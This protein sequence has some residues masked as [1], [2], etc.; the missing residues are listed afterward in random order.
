MRIEEN[1]DLK[2]F[3]SYRLEARC[4]RAFFPETVEE[5]REAFSSGSVGKVLLGSGH[6]IILSKEWYEE[7]FIIFNGNFSNV[8]V[9]A[10]E[11]F[12]EAGSLS[13]VLSEVAL[14]HSLTGLE[15]LYDIPSSL[16]GALVMNAGASGFDIG[17]I[18]KCIKILDLA[19]LQVYDIDPTEAKFG[20]RESIF[21]EDRRMVVLSA[22]LQLEPGD[23]ATILRQMRLFKTQRWAKQPRDLPNAGSVFK[24]PPGG[25]VG[26]MIE[27]VG[28]KGYRL[29]GASISHKHAGIIVNEGGATPADILELIDLARCSVREKYH[30]DLEQEQI[31]V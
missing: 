18:T 3:N 26:P 1:A 21:Q 25:Y 15:F 4:R 11:I 12:A 27:G 7:D 13:H 28:L 30:V 10:G 22:V 20:Y 5:I 2:Q 29:R 14:D 17:S 19:D 23:P 9:R 24:R 31:V 16:G 8:E 6:N